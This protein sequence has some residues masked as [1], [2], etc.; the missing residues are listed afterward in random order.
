MD[1]SVLSSWSSVGFDSIVGPMEELLQGDSSSFPVECFRDYGI[2]GANFS[3][4][5]SKIVNLV[6]ETPGVA[7]DA[8]RQRGRK[9]E[10]TTGVNLEDWRL[11]WLTWF[12]HQ[13]NRLRLSINLVLRLILCDYIIITS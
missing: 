9:G 2:I 13:D 5:S 3:E 6:K 10:S 1:S 8:K 12:R 4:E 7:D 11:A